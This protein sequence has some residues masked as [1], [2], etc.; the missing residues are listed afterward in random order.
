MQ[1]PENKETKVAEAAEPSSE[2]KVASPQAVTAEDIK[3][4][5]AKHQEATGKIASL[6]AD[7][8]RLGEELQRERKAA[9]ERK[10]E[11]EEAR[12]KLE[13]AETK[14]AMLEGDDPKTAEARQQREEL[15][16]RTAETLRKCALLSPDANFED[17]AKTLADDHGAALRVLRKVAELSDAPSMGG[18]SSFSAGDESKTAGV[19]PLT[20]FCLG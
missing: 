11:A 20:A 5:V 9:Q 3:T 6:Q 15:A 4:L 17:F 8:A 19:D 13:G 1:D 7:I 2:Q 14:I 12:S 16:T 18:P 10:R